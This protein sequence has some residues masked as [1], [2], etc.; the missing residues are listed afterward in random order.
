M[1]ILFG[2][3][4]IYQLGKVGKEGAAL[5]RALENVKTKSVAVAKTLASPPKKVD[6]PKASAT[7]QNPTAKASTAKAPAKPK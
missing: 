4:I 6:A 7:L 1:T 5:N 3:F 2:L